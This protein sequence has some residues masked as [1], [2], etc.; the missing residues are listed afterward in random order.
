MKFNRHSGLPG[1]WETIGQLQFDFLLEHGL[2]P[3]SYLLDVGC[4]TFRLGHLAIPY[5]KRKHYFGIDSNTSALEYG[6]RRKLKGLLGR[7]PYIAE[8]RLGRQFVDLI[9]VLKHNAFDYVWIHALLDHLNMQEIDMMFQ[10]IAPMADNVYATAFLSDSV[11]SIQWGRGKKVAI[12]YPDRDPFHH[13]KGILLKVAK[14]RG[15]EFI[16]D[17]EYGH[18]LGLS[19]LYFKGKL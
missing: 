10:S 1:Q 18:P 6:R 3:D 2:K 14:Q 7:S 13:P 4:G 8:V 5:L 16:D 19:M 15:L 17:L 11:H 9:A 12:T